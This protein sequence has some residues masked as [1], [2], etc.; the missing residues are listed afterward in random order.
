M[1]T[2]TSIFL[3]NMPKD[4]PEDILVKISAINRGPESADLH[5][6]AYSMVSQRLV[7]MDC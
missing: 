3:L 2:A 4:G 7:S 1:K 5:L 6:L